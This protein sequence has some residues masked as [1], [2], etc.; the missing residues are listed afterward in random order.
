MKRAARYIAG[1]L[2]LLAGLAMVLYP[3]TTEWR[4]AFA[5]QA[6]AS[7]AKSGAATSTVDT[8]GQA[9][10]KGTIARII[11]TKIGIDAFVLQGTDPKVLDK[12]PG[13]YDKTP[14]PGER[15]NS[16]IAGHRTMHGH[17]FRRLN[18]LKAGDEIVIVTASKRVVYHV[19]SVRVV[20]KADW[21]VVAPC[22]GSRLTLT[23]CHP[24]GSAKQRLVVTAEIA[25]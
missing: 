21:S 14:L 20:D 11:V 5:Q 17:V 10:P 15:G 2:L 22:D 18:E 12:G 7:E 6:L 3:Q 4:Y 23:T 25:K 8:G 1:G 9:M 24:V 19:I 16:A 13:H